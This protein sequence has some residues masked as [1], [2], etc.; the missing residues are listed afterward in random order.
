MFIFPLHWQWYCPWWHTIIL[1]GRKHCHDL[2]GPPKL[3]LNLAFSFSCSDKMKCSFQKKSWWFKEIIHWSCQQSQHKIQICTKGFMTT[4]L[5]HRTLHLGFILPVSFYTKNNTCCSLLQNTSTSFSHPATE[6]QRPGWLI[7]FTRLEEEFHKV[8]QPDSSTHYM[9]MSGLHR[10]LFM[11]A[12]S[13]CYYEWLVLESKHSSV[14][15]H[16]QAG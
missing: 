15:S 2:L 14:I 16:W 6:L 11:G 1:T 3:F 9:E 5:V 7:R 10:K 12:L 13:L 4:R 8:R